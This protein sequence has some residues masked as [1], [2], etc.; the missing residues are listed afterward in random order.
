MHDERNHC[1][2]KQDVN[3]ASGNVE[4]GETA[5]PRDKEDDKKDRPNTHARSPVRSAI[6]MVP[7]G[8][9]FVGAFRA[10]QYVSGVNT[11]EKR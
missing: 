5:N 4:N 6:W 11:V 3:K 9:G 2:H 8:Q 10:V 1:Q 7:H